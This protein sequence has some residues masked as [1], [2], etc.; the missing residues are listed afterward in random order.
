MQMLQKLW[1]NECSRILVC[2]DDYRDGIMEGRSYSPWNE[3]EAFG[4]LSQFLI[5]TEQILDDMGQPQSYTIPR[6]FEVLL[7]E[8]R[9]CSRCSPGRGKRATFELRVLFRQHTSWQGV[10]HWQEKNRD[11]SFRSVL[12]L[13]LLMDNALRSA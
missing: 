8:S 2:V 9:A 6:R 5:Q 10:L 1:L 7:P 11:Q 13:V 3:G 4:S 12:E